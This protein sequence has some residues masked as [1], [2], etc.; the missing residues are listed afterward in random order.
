MTDIRSHRGRVDA[1][2]VR[3][4]VAGRKDISAW[5]EVL[6]TPPHLPAED[7]RSWGETARH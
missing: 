3:G 7:V 2:G 1:G 6:T 5:K 4:T